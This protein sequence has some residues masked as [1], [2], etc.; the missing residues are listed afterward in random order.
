M[1]NLIYV[2]LVLFCFH[3]FSIKAENSNVQLQPKH[4]TSIEESNESILLLS[5]KDFVYKI[6]DNNER[7][8]LYENP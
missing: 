4:F 2:T 5:D 8:V 1:K 6:N 3:V 7:E